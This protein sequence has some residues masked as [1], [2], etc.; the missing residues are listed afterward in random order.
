MLGYGAAVTISDC[1]NSIRVGVVSKRWHLGRFSPLVKH[2]HTHAVIV[3]DNKIDLIVELAAPCG[4]GIASGTGIPRCTGARLH[5][6]GSKFNNLK[7]TKFAFLHSVCVGFGWIGEDRSTFFNCSTKCLTNTAGTCD[8][9]VVSYIANCQNIANLAIA[10]AIDRILVLF[11]EFG[12][13]F[14]LE[15]CTLGGIEANVV[16]LIVEVQRVLI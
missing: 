2:G 6:L 8:G 10:V 7:G 16:R 1:G 14:S 5:F 3:G 15:F 9:I 12:N 13:H 11:D 4:D